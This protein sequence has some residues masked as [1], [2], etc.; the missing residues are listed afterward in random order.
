M[1]GHSKWS[2]VKHQKATTDAVKSSAFT[3]ASRAITIAVKDGGGIADPDGNFKLRLAIEKAHAV[4]MPKD[5]ITRAIARGKGGD[6][7]S[8]F[9]ETYEG[10]GPHGVAFYIETVTDNKQ[11]TVASI[12]QIL[13]HA[14]GSMASPGAVSF[15][16]SRRGVVMKPNSTIPLEE[17][18]FGDVTA[19][20]D[21]LEELDDVQ[22][23]F[24]NA[25]EI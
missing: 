3:R 13:S 15:L 4:N 8:M 1:S 11:R 22:Q 9:S 2:K 5:N 24:T 17:K 23:V 7:Q 18:E 20:T 12:K 21:R 10:Y 19:C 25:E 14:G 6:S 16:F